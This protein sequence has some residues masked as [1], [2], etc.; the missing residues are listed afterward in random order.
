ML[1]LY[2]QAVDQGVEL[3]VNTFKTWYGSI[4][5][6]S[7]ARLRNADI[8]AAAAQLRWRKDHSPDYGNDLSA[9]TMHSSLTPVKLTSQ[10]LRLKRVLLGHQMRRS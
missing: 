8:P 10:L 7:E 6:E 1:D 4:T 5:P 3:I 9:M 2:E